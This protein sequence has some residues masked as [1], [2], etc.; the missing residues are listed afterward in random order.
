MVDLKVEG[1]LHSLDKDGDLQG[2][3][4]IKYKYNLECKCVGSLEVE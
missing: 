3:D 1:N 4:N 2:V